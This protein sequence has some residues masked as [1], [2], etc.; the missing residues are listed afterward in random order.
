MRTLVMGIVNATPDSFSDGGSYLSTEAVLENAERLLADG[1]DL[2]DVGGESTRPGFTPVPEEVELA[3]IIPVI[4]AVADRIEV[5]VDTLHAEVARQAVKAGASIVNDVSGGLFDEN[6]LATVAELGV[7]YI[8]THWRMPQAGLVHELGSTHIDVVAEVLSELG[9]R[10]EACLAAGI[11]EENIIFDPGIGFSKTPD[12]DWQLLRN[13]DL[14]HREL[15]PKWLI[16]VSRKKF[17]GK[18]LD[19]RAPKERDAA[20][21]AITAYCA[22]KRFG[23]NQGVWAVRTHE[24][25]GNRDVTEVIARLIQDV[26]EA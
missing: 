19:G 18:L 6:M 11:P 25:R 7:P 21:Q 2:L 24:V 15:G 13:L 26:P 3:R 8:C 1:A 12:E 14:L 23:P 4:E 22:A 5:S 17:L 10:K 20:T 9:E 16:G